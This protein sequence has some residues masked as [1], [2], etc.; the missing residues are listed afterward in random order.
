MRLQGKILGCGLLLLVLAASVRAVGAEEWRFDDVERIVAFSDVH[1]DYDA[2]VAT[3][4]SAGVIDEE[5]AWC[6]GKTNLVIVGDILDRGPGSR[7]AMDLLM[8][9][10]QE[11]QLAGGRV[12]VLIGNHEVMN[13]VGDMRY[14][15]AGE[16]A[17]FAADESA[18]ERERWYTA[19][20]TQ[21][22]LPGA[23]AVA[24]RNQFDKDFPAG[25]FAHR[26]AF[27]PDGQY[28]EWLLQKPMLVVVDGNAFVHGGLSPSVA[29]GGLQ[30]VNRDLVDD[31]R[32]YARQMQLLMDEGVLLPT[33][34]NRQHVDIVDRVNP[35]TLKGP[36]VI[37][38]V[39][40][41]RRLNDELFSYQSPHWYRGH[42]YCSELIE[43]DRIDAAL[44]KIQANRVIVGHT[45][46]PNR[47]VVE[48][49]DGRVIEIDTGMNNDYYRGSGHALIIENGVV[50]VMNENGEADD[51]P[52]PSAR[53]VGARP[54]AGMSTEDI[55]NVLSFGAAAAASDSDKNLLKVTLDG[56]TLDARFI[57]AKRS[58]IYPDV[59]AYRLDR[60][61]DLDMVPVSVVREY[62]GKWGALQFVPVKSM[63][64]VQRQM[65]KTGGGAWC[66]LPEQW[67]SML[68]FDTLIANDARSADTIYYNLTNW[69]IM[70][71]G[72]NS[73]FTLSTAKSTRFKDGKIRIGRSWR[74]G[75]K[76]ID[77]DTL[78]ATLGDVLDKRRIRALAKRRDLLLSQ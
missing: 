38:A 39:A 61:L 53:R 23:D 20:Q 14:V 35:S 42:T 6:G 71:V 4:Q 47:E 70:L 76:A 41:V 10:E 33:D 52:V 54:V 17:S 26:R 19:W 77:T 49:L 48:R 31:I 57:K 74:D 32:L 44:K 63:D 13:I 64:E 15:H 3:L 8:R 55:E 24:S 69:Q 45:P 75:L 56:R 28:G 50:S 72:F 62:D 1:G 2:M 11:S 60:L 67:T 7:A 68:I 18:E 59:A 58:D 5:L 36:T 27:A 34:P 40:D 30:G 46:T 51:L 9:L 25:F 22:Q 66:P 43:G 65:Q 78:Q 29:E 12:H 73:A 37:E 21:R 16:F